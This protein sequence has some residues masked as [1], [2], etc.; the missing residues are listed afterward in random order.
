VDECILA[1]ETCNEQLNDDSKI[2][3]NHWR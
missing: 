1:C 2:D 3:A